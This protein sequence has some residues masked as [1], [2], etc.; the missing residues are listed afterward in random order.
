MPTVLTEGG[1]KEKD[2]TDQLKEKGNRKVATVTTPTTETG[3]L[4]ETGPNTTKE[5]TRIAKK[6]KGEE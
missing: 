6:E 3:L 2:E 4:L 1:E 5:K